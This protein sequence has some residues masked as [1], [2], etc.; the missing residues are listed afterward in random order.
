M[1]TAADSY[2]PAGTG[3]N[4]LRGGWSPNPSAMPRWPV[5]CEISMP[6][7]GNSVASERM[8]AL[9]VAVARWSWKRSIAATMSSRLVVGACT[10][11]AVPANEMTPTRTSR[12]S[13]PTK[14][15]AASCEAT[16]RLGFTSSARMLPETSIARMIVRSASGSVRTAVGRALASSKSAIVASSSAGGTWRRQPAPLPIASRAS[17]MLGSRTA[18]RRR[19]RIAQT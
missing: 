13:A 18:L 8:I 17:A 11:A 7:S 14:L 5:T 4:S 2:E 10:S 3:L 16:R 19:R 12:G 1:M 15:L 9:P 6:S